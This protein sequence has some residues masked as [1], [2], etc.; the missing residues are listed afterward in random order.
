MEVTPIFSRAR[1]APKTLYAG[2][3]PG[4][5]LNMPIL[6][7]NLHKT[8]DPFLQGCLQQLNLDMLPVI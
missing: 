5:L 6:A 3:S 4:T 2:D 7:G 8:H 1:F